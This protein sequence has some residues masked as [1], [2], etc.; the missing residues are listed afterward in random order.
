MLGTDVLMRQPLGFLC[1]IGEH[2]LAL[3]AQR[4]VHGGRDL[5][6]NGGVTFD[7]F[8]NG[9]HRSMGPKEPIGEC[10]VLAQQTQQQVLRLDVGRTELT[11]FVAREENYSPGLFRV[12]FK[13]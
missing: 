9:F 7:L 10:L 6:A 8:T 11:G 12:P 2:T 13:H 5:L 4:Q 3:I 1:G